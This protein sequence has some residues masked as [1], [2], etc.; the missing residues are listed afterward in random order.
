MPASRPSAPDLLAVVMEYLEAD[1]APRLPAVQQFQLKIVARALSTVKRELEQGPAADAGEAERLA[2]LLRHGGDLAEQRAELARAI[3]HGDFAVDDPAL[4]AHL[5]TTVED[6][7]R[8]NN[9]KWL[10]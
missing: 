3:R 1:I 4:L 6:A 8:I 9:P 7:L 5:C 10:T 2:A